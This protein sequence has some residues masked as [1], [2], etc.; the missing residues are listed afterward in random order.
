MEALI[1]GITIQDIAVT[2]T[3]NMEISLRTTLEHIL[4]KS[5]IDG[6]VKPHFSVVT[7]LVISERIVQLGLRHLILNLTKAR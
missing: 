7:R 6:Q 1:I 3:K 2:I 5:I 4:V